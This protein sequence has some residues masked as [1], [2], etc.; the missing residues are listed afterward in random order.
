M[1]QSGIHATISGV[2]LAFTIPFT[3]LDSKQN[4]LDSKQKVSPSY[5][6]QHWLHKPV[7]F[8]ILPL[9]ALANTGIP[10]GE[11]WINQLTSSN[12]VG[13]M[14][15]LFVGKTMG[16]L[17]FS[18]VLIKSK[19]G[20]LPEAVQ[21]K[22][23]LGVAILAGIGFTMSIFIANLAFADHSIIQDSKVAILSGS[24]ISCLLG[25]LVL[26]WATNPFLSKK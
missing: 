2:L 21:W 7:A 20:Q 26:R 23:L 14:T 8:I 17:F 18:W 15:G 22:H 24:L 6:L 5:S 3:S 11:G 16:I 9:F 25:L 12:S 10:L 1:Y 4:S 13:I 19:W